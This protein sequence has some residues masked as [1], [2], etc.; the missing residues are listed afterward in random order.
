V[1]T[2]PDKYDPKNIHYVL[3]KWGFVSIDRDRAL[4]T[5]THDNADPL[6]VGKTK[7]ELIR[8]FGYLRSIN[9]ASPYLRDYC[10]YG[11]GRGGKSVGFLRET[12]W[13]VV[14]ENGKAVELVLCKG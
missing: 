12:N 13:M 4:G 14:F 8:R 11:S 2:Y 10:Y 6:V 1:A 3:W 5:M 9:E 7:S